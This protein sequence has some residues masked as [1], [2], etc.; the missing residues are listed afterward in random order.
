MTQ[1]YLRA[2]SLVI[3][4]DNDNTLLDVSELHFQFQTQAVV[5][6]TPGSVQLRVWNLSGETARSIT[7]HGNMIYLSAG[8]EGNQD[9]IFQ[10]NIV[11]ARIGRNGVDSYL[12]ITAVDGDQIH[13]YGFIS[14]SV[15]SGADIIGRIGSIA[16]AANIPLGNIGIPA[17]TSQ[18]HRGRAYFGLARDHLTGLC[19]T[20]GANWN[21]NNGKLEIVAQNAYKPGDVPL[22]TSATGMIGVPEQM[23]EGI[24][25]RVLLNPAI[26]QNE[27]VQLD[28]ASIQQYQYGL[29]K[30]STSQI[31][32]QPSL[33][34][35]GK[36][37][38]LYVTHTGDTRGDDWYTDTVCYAGNFIS[39]LDQAQYQTT[40]SPMALY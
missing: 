13:N 27:L 39:N 35:D 16:K 32:F 31:N 28:N 24:S 29:D 10:G 1:Q 5:L 9:L 33:S 8:Y 12:D 3:E 2:A 17:N 21:I 34:A 18:L 25:I 38:V 19:S 20:V 6:Q 4:L 15:K 11:Q 37:K 26:H 36:Y 40:T 30:Q 14:L 22:L 23:E 7:G